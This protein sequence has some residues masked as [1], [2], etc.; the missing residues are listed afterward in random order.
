MY[1][2]QLLAKFF[3]WLRDGTM[4]AGYV[5]PD[6]EW[7]ED[8]LLGIGAGNRVF[9]VDFWSQKNMWNELALGLGSELEQ[10][11]L[12]LADRG[13]NGRKGHLFRGDIISAAN[14]KTNVLTRRHHRNVSISSASPLSSV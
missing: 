9:V 11:R 7:I 4:P 8:V 10:G 3:A 2:V 13:M 12:A 5:N 6:A 1:E 14:E